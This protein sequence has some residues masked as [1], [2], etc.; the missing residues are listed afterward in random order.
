MSIAGLL[1]LDPYMAERSFCKKVQRILFND[2]FSTF[3]RQKLPALARVFWILCIPKK[4]LAT[5]CSSD[6]ARKNLMMEMTSNSRSSCSVGL[7]A[8][9]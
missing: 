3:K 9:C 5:D 6:Q 1:D 8:N 2:F 4:L 7:S